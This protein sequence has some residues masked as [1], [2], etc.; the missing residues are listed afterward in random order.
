MALAAPVAQRFVPSSG[1]TAMSTPSKDRPSVPGVLGHAHLLADEQ[2][3]RLVALALADDDGAVDGHGVHLA[4]HRLDGG[5]V[6]QVPV[7]LPHRVRAGDRRL[8]HDAQELEREVRF[9][10]AVLL[11]RVLHGG[12][13][14]WGR[15]RPAETAHGSRGQVIRR[16]TTRRAARGAAA[17]PPRCRRAPQSRGDRC[18]R[19]ARTARPRRPRRRWRPAVEPVRTRR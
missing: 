16:T 3:R 9:H 13:P 14:I 7:A 17:V 6:R 19:T 18:C 15:T 12:C 5:L 2:H 4:A 1:S 10:L 8:L 11:N